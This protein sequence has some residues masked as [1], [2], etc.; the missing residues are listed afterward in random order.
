MWY[1]SRKMAHLL[2]SLHGL[3]GRLGDFWRH[4]L[5]VFVACRPAD[6]FNLFVGLWLV[7]LYI[8]PDELG[9]VSPLLQYA[10]FLSMPASVFAMTF[11]N[12]LSG[13]AV[14]REFG[15]MKS[16]MRGVFLATAVFLLIAIV[17]S[18]FI[19]PIFLE[20][21][22]LVE[23]SLGTL[24]LLSAF[25]GAVAPVY[26]NAIQS[27]KKFRE[28][29]IINVL[30]APIRLVTMLVTMPIR[31]IS[32]YF[33]GQ[34][35]TPMFQIVASLFCLRKELG[36]KAEPYWNLSVARRFGKLFLLFGIGSA[37][38]SICALVEST[39]LRQRLP[40]IDSAGYYMVTRFS[41]ISGYLATSLIFTLFPYAA[42]VSARGGSTRPLVLK[43]CGALVSFSGVLALFFVLFGE[44]L[45]SFF[46]HGDE[47]A[48]Y[49]W[50]IPWAVGIATASQVVSAYVT[51]EIS[52]NRFGYLRWLAPLTLGYPALLLVVTGY[53][54]F[55]TIIPASWS[56]FLSTH[57][58][59]SLKTMMWWMTGFAVAKLG[60]CARSIWRD[61]R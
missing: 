22:R 24:V 28:F 25:V 44:R 17:V 5:M 19:L 30:G 3:C 50:A 35:A 31:A 11:R 55:D 2:Q 14:R 8:S 6:L 40:A 12:E 61:T 60:F 51:A 57:N 56:E 45:L 42:E 54:Y 4:S 16:L 18:R 52:A 23:G 13:L 53:G 59:S 46:P 33:A 39:V 47:Y 27:L 29:S 21:I 20:R 49:W 32:G 34:S 38:G 43:V 41:E 48:P 7:P 1:N 15:R 37:T 9:A 36:V 26:Q 10:G 58:I